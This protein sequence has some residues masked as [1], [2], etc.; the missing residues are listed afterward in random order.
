M[1]S[2]AAACSDASYGIVRGKCNGQCNGKCNGN[3][4]GDNDGI[5]ATA[6]RN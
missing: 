3:G 5:I 6:P 4:N 1:T 2:L